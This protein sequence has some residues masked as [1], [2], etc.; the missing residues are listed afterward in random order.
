MAYKITTANS[1]CALNNMEQS[2]RN[3]LSPNYKCDYG[4]VDCKAERALSVNR[5]NDVVIVVTNDA[6][7]LII[8]F[9]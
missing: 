9:P 3:T 4:C 8:S 6:R 2:W 7:V 5:V 1:L